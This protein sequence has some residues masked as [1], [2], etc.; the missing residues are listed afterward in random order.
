MLPEGCTKR[1]AIPE[2]ILWRCLTIQLSE[3]ADRFGV[4]R[5]KCW[6]E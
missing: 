1:E 2:T 4:R 6:Q 5:M 3:A